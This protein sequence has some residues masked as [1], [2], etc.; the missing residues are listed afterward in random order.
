MKLKRLT[1]ML[2]ATAMTV[3]MANVGFAEETL[4][5]P[6]ILAMSTWFSSNDTQIEVTGGKIYFE[7][8][9]GTIRNSDSGITSVVIPEKIDGIP[10][11]KIG[12]NAFS[13]CKNLTDITLPGSLTTIDKDAF[14]NC[15]SLKSI[16]IPG[17]VETIGAGAFY[18]CSN[19]E[20]VNILDGVTTIGDSMF[21]NCDSLTNITLPST[22][23]SIGGYAFN[24]CFDLKHISLPD[25]IT[26][27]GEK[28]FYQCNSLTN[29]NIPN[30]ITEI[31][32]ETFA[33]CSDLENLILPDGI[34]SIGNNAF[35][36]CS[37]LRSITIPNSVTAIG[38]YAFGWCY[39]LREI[40]IPTG[41]KTIGRST[42]YSCESLINISLPDSIEN[43]ETDAFYN[44]VSLKQIKI[45]NNVN[46]ISDY[47][48]SGCNNL[49]DIVIPNT[50]NSIGE[51]AFK[52]I[53]NNLN[54]YCYKNSVSDNINL[55]NGDFEINFIYL[56]NTGVPVFTPETLNE[57][58]YKVDGGNIYFNTE[59]GT[60]TDCDRNVTNVDIPEKINGINV[61]SIGE[62]A[63]AHSNITEINIPGSIQRIEKYAFYSCYELKKVSIQKGVKYIGED[64]FFDCMVLRDITLSEGLETIDDGAFA[65][66]GINAAGTEFNVIIPKTV[67]YIGY[68][69]FFGVFIN[70]LTFKG[71][72]TVIS[73]KL[74]DNQYGKCYKI[75]CIKDSTAEKYATENNIPY[76]L[77]EAEPISIVAT[78]GN[79]YF[80]PDTQQIVGCDSSVTAIEIPESIDGVEISGISENA[81]ADCLSFESISIP[82]TVKTISKNTFANCASLKSVTCE[83]GS[84]A[85]NTQLYP[86]TTEITY[87][88]SET[89]FAYGDATGDGV[90]TAAD[91]AMI[92]EKSLNLDFAT[93]IEKKTPDYVKYIDVTGDGKIDAND[94]AIV[95]QKSLNLDFVMPCEK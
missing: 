36:G 89:T 34:I 35:D 15:T 92:L 81:F 61:T 1:A 59:T 25:S 14:Y 7:A 17:S 27:I 5:N 69:V 90:I 74:F 23:T 44:C 88:D 48:F 45:P 47:A 72:N 10:V 24:E 54:V 39:N 3:G 16:T 60:I 2:L 82:S 64:A 75:Y 22:L 77:I 31:S 12:E 18:R 93:D 29:I 70:N 91:A 32:N 50:V 94:A 46:Q 55:Y 67:N 49:T 20:T 4:E 76:E 42:F 71:K 78:G 84:A 65:W 53:N 58:S 33:G 38:N 57:I 8:S 87:T 43:I 68:H 79:I 73:E 26:S 37:G 66:C 51:Y 11:T 63:F 95:L 83:K 30:N 6:N 21:S 62:Y 19:L 52:G 85:D 40:S 56:D 9:T 80:N 41:I 28:A 13:D 86:T